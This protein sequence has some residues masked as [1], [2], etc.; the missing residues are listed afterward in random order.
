MPTNFLSRPSMPRRMTKVRLCIS[1]AV[2]LLESI[3]TS[4][5]GLVLVEIVMS[6]PEVIEREAAEDSRCPV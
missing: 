1:L 3:L 5:S 6:A 4:Q 2:A